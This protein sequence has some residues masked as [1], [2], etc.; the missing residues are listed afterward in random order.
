MPHFSGHYKVLAQLRR[1][2]ESFADLRVQIGNALA[3]VRIEDPNDS[4]EI[5]R[6][7][8]LVYS[9]CEP[10]LIRAEQ[11]VDRSPA[12][13]ALRGGVSSFGVAAAGALAGFVAGGTI[14]SA[15][16]SA[17]VTKG[18]E[19]SVSFA[20]NLRQRQDSQRIASAITTFFPQSAGHGRAW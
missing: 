13:A 1:S 15:L 2:E 12:L 9:R 3:E 8:S 16:T 11:T 10:S 19:T 20:T 18:V 6:A 7:R 14:A 4:N 5:G 17:G